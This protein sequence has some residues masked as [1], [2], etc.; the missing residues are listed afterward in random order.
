VADEPGFDRTAFCE[1]HWIAPET[2]VL[3]FVALGHFTRQ[4]LR[5]AIEALRRAENCAAVL[6]GCGSPEDE[7]RPGLPTVQALPKLPRPANWRR[8]RR[9][10]I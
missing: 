9:A 6:T 2:P 1:E 8:P 10:G 3:L 4:G 7:G 5:L